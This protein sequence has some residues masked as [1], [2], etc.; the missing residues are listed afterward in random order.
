MI[1]ID[2]EEV[3]GVIP[4]HVGVHARQEEVD[5]VGDAGGVPEMVKPDKSGVQ[6]ITLAFKATSITVTKTYFSLA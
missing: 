6:S 3:D 2:H 1:M 4:A 5:N